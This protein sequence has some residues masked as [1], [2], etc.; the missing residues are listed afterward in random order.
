[1]QLVIGL[2]VLYF[3]ARI[4]IWF[5][6]LVFKIFAGICE[7]LSLDDDSIEGFAEKVKRIYQRL[8]RTDK[9]YHSNGQLK[10]ETHY[11]WGR[12]HGFV[13]QYYES[14]QMKRQTPY[15]WGSKRGAETEYYESGRVKSEKTY[16]GNNLSG[17]AKEYG[18]NGRLQK[19]TLYV[20]NKKN[21]MEKCYYSTGELLSRTVY[22]G[23][24]K[25][26]F[27]D[28]YFKSG[29]LLRKSYYISSLKEREEEEFYDV[30]EGFDNN[31]E[32]PGF[33]AIDTER[34]PQFYR[35]CFFSQGKK[36][37]VESVYFNKSQIFGTTPYR[38]GKIE[39]IQKYYYESGNLESETPYK[40][41]QINGIQR[42]YYESGSLESE[43]PYSNGLQ[44]GSE[45]S[46]YENGTL[47]MFVPYKKGVKDGKEK[48]YAL[49][50][51]LEEETE[52]DN[53]VEVAYSAY[54]ESGVLKETAKYRNGST[55]DFLTRKM[56]NES[57]ITIY[58]LTKDGILV[59]FDDNGNPK[60]GVYKEYT[61]DN[62]LHGE[63]TYRNGI[64][65]GPAKEYY[66]NGRIRWEGN[67]SN[68][69]ITG[70]GRHCLENGFY[71]DKFELYEYAV[72]MMRDAEQK[73]ESFLEKRLL[74]SNEEAKEFI[75]EM[76]NTNVLSKPDKNGNRV[77][78]RGNM[79]GRLLDGMIA[80]GEYDDVIISN[81]SITDTYAVENSHAETTSSGRRRNI[82]G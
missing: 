18:R 28:V 38:N 25:N 52:F 55:S 6:K 48:K 65:N 79:R 57:G 26:G 20:G 15:S 34:Y 43:T 40:N 2:I 76:E 3:I 4:A 8:N 53:G 74:L 70:E 21:G 35:K 31:S 46:Y 60:N 71:L 13:L 69:R 75:R 44:N 68:N 61:D 29:K 56:F 36:D 80:S 10:E 12:K 42:Y 47:A 11:K 58:E 51:A 63:Y 5:L 81:D 66:A 23:G 78:I 64:K 45:K 1:M 14:G 39:G 30:S 67:Y 7:Q 33:S 9:S 49:S 32:F 50:G 22:S 77:F 24:E 27:E 82:V 37:G 59:E 72:N 62:V 16:V 17:L 54:Y 73:N 41:N 19:E